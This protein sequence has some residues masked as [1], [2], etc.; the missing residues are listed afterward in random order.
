MIWQAEPAAA[1][2][3]PYGVPDLVQ[4]SIAISLKRI[5][6]AQERLADEAER[7]VVTQESLSVRVTPK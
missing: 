7:E 5:A 1:G 2:D 3:L 6:D 4:Y